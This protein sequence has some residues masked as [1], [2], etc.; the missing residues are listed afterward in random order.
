[1]AEIR[2]VVGDTLAYIS[3][4]IDALDPAYAPGTGTPV[5]GGMTAFEAQQTLRGLA[6]LN[7][8][9]ADLVEVSPPWDPSGITAIAGCYLLWD[10]LCLLALSPAFPPHA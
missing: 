5:S 3:F 10:L 4:D 2:R 6:G 9:G 1:M 8:V 7:F